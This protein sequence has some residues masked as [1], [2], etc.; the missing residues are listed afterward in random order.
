[1]YIVLPHLPS[2]FTR[3]TS[4]STFYIE[5]ASL[6][7]IEDSP[8]TVGVSSLSLQSPSSHFYPATSNE[9]GET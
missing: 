3:K 7:R 9:L 8:K 6:E 5:N 1:M 2:N 4:R